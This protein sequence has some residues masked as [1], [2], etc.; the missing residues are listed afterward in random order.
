VSETGGIALPLGWTWTIPGSV[1]LAPG[2]NGPQDV[3]AGGNA[4]YETDLTTAAPLLN[5]QPIPITGRDSQGR[6][7]TLLTGPINRIV[8]IRELRKLVL[9]CDL[10]VFWATIPP[11]GGAYLFAMAFLPGNRFSGLAEEPQN[12][13]V[14]GAWGTDLVNHFGI[15][16]GTWSSP[17]GA[18]TFTRSTILGVKPQ[19]MRRIDL[20]AHANSRQVM[21]AVSGGGN[22]QTTKVDPK[23]GKIVPDAFGNVQWN[24]D[25]FIL[26]VLRS[27]DGGQTWRPTE[28]L[29]TGEVLP[30]FPG[31]P[32][33]DLAGHTSGGYV[34][35]VGVSPFNPDLVAVGVSSWFLSHDGGK[36]WDR[37]G[38]ASSFHRHADTH[39]LVFDP[40]DSKVLHVRSDGA[41]ASTPDLGTTWQTATNRQLPNHQL[42]R[43]AASP[44][45]SG[46]IAASAQDNG[47]LDT[48]L[49]V[50]P[51]P[52]NELD[53]G[54]GYLTMFVDGGDLIRE[55]NTLT[56]GV[57]EYGRKARAARWDTVDQAFHDIT[58]FPDY[59]L[60]RGVIPVDGTS[61]GLAKLTD[62]ADNVS[63]VVAGPIFANG[64]GEPLVGVAAEGEAVFSLFA[65]GDGT[66]HWT[67]L[68]TIL[69]LPDLNADGTEKAY[70]AT[71][72][73]ATPDGQ[74]VF[75]G[76]NNGKIF[77]IDSPT[78]NVVNLSDPILKTSTW[79]FSVRTS[80]RLFLIADSGVFRFAGGAWG[81]LTGK[82]LPGGV[83]AVLP[84][85]VTFT[86]LA[87]D[88]TT[89][90]PRLFV[91]ASTGVW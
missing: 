86:A 68:A 11:P 78:G 70:F 29:V 22:C 16:V 41:L 88:P 17:A 49:Y 67:P 32:A 3:Y 42:Y 35:C 36:H 72:S 57:V 66:F 14:A 83:S 31:G 79:R 5:W 89:V 55:T 27:I 81:K 75:V 2:I 69:H 63:E 77:R 20:A 12:T 90:P 59:P 45:D 15:F 37:S 23:T 58:M 52:W 4:L 87:A 46:V 50:W 39:G 51:V 10:G 44:T 1:C 56:V 18:P 48:S 80:D 30:L 71:T 26:T 76:T 62:N 34:G 28:T 74:A 19:Q 84:A 24:E 43:F 33:S 61:D 65:R 8:V 54:D 85:D 38:E 13:V 7:I 6:E 21:Y 82:I 40:T 64:D 53:E 91:G 25:D 9:A 73:A 47:N 60:S